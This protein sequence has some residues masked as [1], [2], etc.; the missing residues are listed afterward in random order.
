MD[1][2]NHEFCNFRASL[3]GVMKLINQTGIGLSS[4]KAEPITPLEEEMWAKGTF[5]SETSSGLLHAVYFHNCKVFT[6]LA[7]IPADGPFN[8]RP[9]AAKD[10]KLRYSQQKV[11]IHT[12]QKM[13]KTMCEE[14]G[15]H[16]RFTGHSG[17]VTLTT[18]LFNA[19]VDEQLI[20]A[21][22]GH[23]SN[24]VR[25]YKRGSEE[26]NKEIPD[27]LQPTPPKKPEEKQADVPVD[28]AD[29]NHGNQKTD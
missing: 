17:K 29:A 9:L 22:T 26:I 10:G 21:R 24:A 20:I 6:Y 8:R 2:N 14:A 13:F 7:A 11:G 27:Q 1:V 15:L 18:T 5:S 16:G 4:R 25:V 23:R 19:K 12:L 3:D 28:D